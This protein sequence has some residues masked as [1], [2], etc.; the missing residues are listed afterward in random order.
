MSFGQHRLPPKSEHISAVLDVLRDQE[1][2]PAAE[3]LKRSG[4]TRTQ[5]Y[6]ALSYLE[7]TE[8]IKVTHLSKPKKILV[9]LTN[10][11]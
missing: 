11:E 10:K 4:L 2:L 6:C 7:A 8:Q 3:I 1:A 5:T 9:S